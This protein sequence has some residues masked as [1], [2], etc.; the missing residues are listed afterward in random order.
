MYKMNK[1]YYANIFFLNFERSDKLKFNVLIQD[2]NV[3]L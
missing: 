1:K 3:I 2:T